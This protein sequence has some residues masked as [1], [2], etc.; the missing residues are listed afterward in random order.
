LNH[1]GSQGEQRS[2][3]LALKMAEI[4]Y[5]KNRWGN[6]PVLLLDDMTS[7]LD[8]DRNGNFMSFLKKQEMQVF[9][10]TTSL[11]NISLEGM[12]YYSTFPVS[13]GRLLTEV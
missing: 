10:T 12:G 7:E 3:V 13:N 4:E 6:P 9:I 5:L 1:H 2:F 8:R 11:D